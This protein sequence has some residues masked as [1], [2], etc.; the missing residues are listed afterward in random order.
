VVVGLREEALVL[1]AQ[2]LEQA[3]LWVLEAQALEQP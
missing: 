3:W 1:K 2:T